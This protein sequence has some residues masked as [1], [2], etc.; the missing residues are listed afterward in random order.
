MEKKLYL[1]RHGKAKQ[2][3]PG[4]KDRDRSLD[5]EGMRK[6]AKLGVYFY[7]NEPMISAILSSSASRSMETAEQLASQVGFDISKIIADDEL[8][9]SSVRIILE[10]I[11]KMND[12]WNVV[13]IVGH[14]PALSYFVEYIT[15]HHFDGMEPGSLVKIKCQLESW[16][17]LSVGMAFF[18][19]YLGPSDLNQTN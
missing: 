4:E 3:V 8:Y 9:D 18:D 7:R 13:I 11:T 16:K 5:A 2:V 6:A 12:S 15:G 10:T 14:N 17:D 1:I 19:T